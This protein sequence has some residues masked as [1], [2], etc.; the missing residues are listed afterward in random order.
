MK[1]SL[2]TA[3]EII[4]AL[5]GYLMTSEM[6]GRQ[7]RLGRWPHGAFRCEWQSASRSDWLVEQEDVIKYAKT[8]TGFRRGRPPKTD[9]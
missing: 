5:S 2:P 3:A 7:I 8:Y 4:T 6:L 9:V 1:I